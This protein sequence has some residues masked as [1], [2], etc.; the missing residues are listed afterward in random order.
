MD[1]LTSL[2]NHGT[3]QRDLATLI[4]VGDPFSLLMLDLDLFKTFNDTYGHPAGD[5][6][7]GVVGGAL[8]GA[9]RQNDQAYRYGG[10]EF[11]LLLRGAPV[12]VAEE[13]AARVRTA[14][15][16]AVASSGIGDGGIEVTASVGSACWPAD[17]PDKTQ[18]V[19]AADAAL[20]RAKRL[21]VAPSRLS[22]AS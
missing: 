8:V 6:L 10:D 4:E 2:R 20:Y 7:L 1:A 18:L 22:R 14:V 15:R 16:E 17:G 9:I 21:R 13:V 19:A 11:A 12:K 5:A 3:F